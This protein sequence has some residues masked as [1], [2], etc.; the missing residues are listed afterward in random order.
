MIPPRENFNYDPYLN[1]VSSDMNPQESTS[2]TPSNSVPND[3]LTPR[4]FAQNDITPEPSHSSNTTR[5]SS[6]PS[7]KDTKKQLTSNKSN[8]RRKVAPKKKASSNGVSSLQNSKKRKILPGPMSVV[9]QADIVRPSLS[10]YVKSLSNKES[11]LQPISNQFSQLPT[12]RGYQYPA[13]QLNFNAQDF[14]MSTEYEIVGSEI[15]SENHNNKTLNNTPQF[16]NP[17]SNDFINPQNG[18]DTFRGH[19]NPMM[20]LKITSDSMRTKGGPQVTALSNHSTPSSSTF[21]APQPIGTLTYYRPIEI[22][23]NNNVGNGSQIRQPPL[24]GAPISENRVE[25]QLLLARHH[26]NFG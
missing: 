25:Q 16:Q 20:C 22:V 23:Q 5:S 7:N 17:N 13:M 10:D 2:G 11:L 12:A 26:Y 18:R 9:S 6:E 14:S 8:R 19:S 4:P 3:P 24:S 21:S 1:S 15:T